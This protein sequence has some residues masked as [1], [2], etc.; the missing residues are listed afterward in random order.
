MCHQRKIKCDLDNK[1]ADEKCTRCGDLGRE[2][3]LYIR[4]RRTSRT[5]S[6]LLAQ[7]RLSGALSQDSFYSRLR[8]VAL[9]PKAHHPNNATF[10]R[11]FKSGWGFSQEGPVTAKLGGGLEE[12]ASTRFEA[13]L[14]NKLDLD[15]LSKVGC[16][17]LPS[18][19]T[20]KQYFDI[21]FEHIN[22]VLPLVPQREF[23]SQ[24]KGLQH[25]PSLALLQS[26]LCISSKFKSMD[27]Q[28]SKETREAQLETTA[29]L[30]KRSKLL[31][32][33]DMEPNQLRVLQCL[34]YLSVVNLNDD[35]VNILTRLQ[36]F[37][38]ESLKSP[39]EV[40][41]FKK[42]Y[43]FW[44]FKFNYISFSEIHDGTRLF[45]FAPFK[46]IAF[47]TIEDDFDNDHSL[48]NIALLTLYHIADL[49][50]CCNELNLKAN[51][52]ASNAKPFDHITKQIDYKFFQWVQ[53]VDSRLFYKL[54]DKNSQTKSAAVITG[55]A[56][57]MLM[58][59][60]SRNLTRH[61]LFL[62][63]N[64]SKN[65]TQN[66]KYIPSVGIV[67]LSTLMSLTIFNKF[68]IQDLFS[69]MNIQVGS[70]YFVHVDR[71]VSALIECDES[72]LSKWTYNAISK[73]LAISVENMSMEYHELHDNFTSKMDCP[74][75]TLLSRKYRRSVVHNMLNTHSILTCTNSEFNFKLGEQDLIVP[76][77]FKVTEVFQWN[78]FSKD[79]KEPIG[80][81]SIMSLVLD[82]DVLIEKHL[83]NNY[84][85]IINKIET[86]YLAHFTSFN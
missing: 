82:T 51:I 61:R 48:Q 64:Q 65:Q 5:L 81:I 24:H 71:M 31:L 7:E 6:V 15:Y 46:E 17:H 50:Q 11:K 59:I 34:T 55:I 22:P 56:Y 66:L 83:L 1:P 8:S 23:L 36:N 79:I 75:Q 52:L 67:L 58:V 49:L 30:Y 72:L 80:R 18:Y 29:L 28:N 68:K 47:L 3:V 85:D 84:D 33:N 86:N 2:C 54:D 10:S 62:R 43:W 26:I 78:G 19:T 35:S 76:E 13:L 69:P 74:T 27:C 63:T 37:N 53:T 9:D 40:S 38:Q 73:E 60:H 42:M 41:I 16:F 70:S 14:F 57:S 32:D 25:V 21:F 39:R 45:S 77:D 44:A 4:K 20:C 12:S